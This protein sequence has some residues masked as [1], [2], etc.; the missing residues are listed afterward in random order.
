[1]YSQLVKYAAAGLLKKLAREIAVWKAH[2]I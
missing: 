1:M 2:S